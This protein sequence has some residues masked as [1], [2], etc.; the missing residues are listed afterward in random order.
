M[1]C[2]ES[3]L[4]FECL[5]DS[6]VGVL[7]MP[8]GM[9][10][11]LGVLIAVGGPQYR[12]GSH[13]QFVLLARR[14]ADAGYPTLRFDVRGMGDSEGEFPGFE[15]LGPDLAAATSAFQRAAPGVRRVVVWG[16]CD[17]ASAALMST[18]AVPTWAG[19]VLLNPWVRH[20]TT[21]ARTEIRH[22]YVKR[23]ADPA[24]WKK[25]LSGHVRFAS[26]VRE[27][28]GKLWRIARSRS[29]R[30]V[31]VADAPA[32]YRE[33]MTLGAVSFKGPQLYIL[34]GRDLVC[35]EFLG[36]AASHPKWK[37]L[38]QRSEVRRIDLPGAD[39]TFS[40]HALRL[41]VEVATLKFLGDISG[42]SAQ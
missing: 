11:D 37:A 42:R 18:S 25:L 7:S 19:L 32:D 38:W 39:H 6:L 27:I 5:Q 13:R 29:G 24:F 15:A 36:Y 14:L 17:A 30:S 31:M 21:H 4:R 22:Y 10:S 33:R 26:S 3:G 23:L 12:A 9:V 40:S 8:I 16:L 35:A 28:A 41:Q 34:S 2:T 20:P 1:K